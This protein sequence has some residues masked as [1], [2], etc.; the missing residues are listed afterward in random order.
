V[1]SEDAQA[2][3]VPVRLRCYEDLR[4]ERTRQAC[5]GL[6]ESRALYRSTELSP[7]RQAE[8]INASQTTPLRRSDND[9]RNLFA[10]GTVRDIVR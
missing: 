4:I 3:V 10:T 8:R 1:L 6:P 7:G 5:D 2:A 9:M